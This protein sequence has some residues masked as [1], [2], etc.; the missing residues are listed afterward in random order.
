MKPS[1]NVSDLIATCNVQI[2]F[3]HSLDVELAEVAAAAER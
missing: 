3:N 2:R 1:L